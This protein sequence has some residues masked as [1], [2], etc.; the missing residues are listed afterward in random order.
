M[1]G[2]LPSLSCVAL[3]GSFVPLVQGNALSHNAAVRERAINDFNFATGS[4]NCGNYM[5]KLGQWVPDIAVLADSAIK[6]LDAMDDIFD[7]YLLDITFTLNNFLGID[8]AD[9]IATA[10]GWFSAVK[11]YSQGHFSDFG[12]SKA[13]M[14]C[15]D[16]YQVL[17]QGS[18]LAQE[19]DG[20]TVMVNG[21]EKR[22][23]E[24]TDYVTELNSGFVPFWIKDLGGYLFAALERFRPGT[25]GDRCSSAFAFT[26]NPV[27][28]KS[29][30][31]FCIY[32]STAAEGKKPIEY[33]AAETTTAARALT[34]AGSLLDGDAPGSSIM[35]HEMFHATRGNGATNDHAKHTAQCTGAVIA[36][37]KADAQESPQCAV[38]FAVAMDLMFAGGLDEIGDPKNVY[39][40]RGQSMS[41]T[42]A[43]NEL[44]KSA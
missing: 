7:P 8:S 41:H 21:E 25:P 9:D 29:S 11:S 23:N 13:F 18:D 30:I 24:I 6:A 5:P 3:V 4:G 33:F 16:N 43:V 20:T 39:W 28:Q 32:P 17:K 22:I 1:R 26:S 15:G 10:R 36:G 31:S 37:N 14:F 34:F 44:T 38:L 2:K 42:G 19:E 40:W 35:M 27:K 12:Y